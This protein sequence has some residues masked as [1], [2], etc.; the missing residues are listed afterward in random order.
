MKRR[1]DALYT[2]RVWSHART[3]TCTTC[4][5]RRA[6]S[7][8][9]DAAISEHI[10]CMRAEEGGSRGNSAGVYGEVFNAKHDM[11]RFNESRRSMKSFIYGESVSWACL[12]TGETLNEATHQQPARPRTFCKGR[13]QCK[14]FV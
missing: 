11:I 10:L 8:Y 1:R 13:C 5:R 12:A 3:Y 14:A 2:E 4:Y 7:A 6:Y 9:F